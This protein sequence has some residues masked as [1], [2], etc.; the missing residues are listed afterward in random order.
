MP[1]FLALCGSS[2]YMFDSPPLSAGDWPGGN[3]T[4]N[5]DDTKTAAGVMQY[6]VRARVMWQ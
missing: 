3:D 4:E 2:V 6:K 5:G 1:R